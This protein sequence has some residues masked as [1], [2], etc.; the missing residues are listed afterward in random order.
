MPF[1]LDRRD[2]NTAAPSSIT[3]AIQTRLPSSTSITAMSGWGNSPIIIP[4]S[5]TSNSNSSNDP[6]DYNSSAFTT[7][8]ITYLAIIVVAGVLV[9]LISSR[10]F[11]IRRYYP[12]PS[13]RAYFL[14]QNGIH[15][16]KIGLHIKGAP[17][18]IRQPVMT[19]LQ[20]VYGASPNQ[21]GEE[22]RERRRRRR[23]R[24]TV[25][26]TLGP[27]GTRIGDRDSD[28]GWDY[29]DDIDL[30]EQGR[31]GGGGR[32]GELPQYQ[33]DSGLP[34]YVAPPPIPTLNSS[35]PTPRGGDDEVDN[36]LPSAAEYEALS[37]GNRDGTITYP[38][39]VHVHGAVTSPSSLYP[40]E[41]PPSFSRANSGIST[42]SRRSQRRPTT[43][44]TTTTTNVVNTA[45]ENDSTST[46]ETQPEEEGNEEG[47]RRR[48]STVTASSSA[49][50]L[51]DDEEDS[52]KV[53]T[54]GS[55]KVTLGSS[56]STSNHSTNNET[57]E[58][59]DTQNRKEQ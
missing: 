20:Q 1:T 2:A 35:T 40:S 43:T 16:D 30:V 23:N 22:R 59:E 10:Y 11:Y 32:G 49:S 31:G 5:S 26:E 36:Y 14:P 46:F 18:R 24:Q 19:T 56:S 50:K 48:Q 57:K 12:H 39:P 9:A 55:S 53:V 52:I 3:Q 8:W 45:N 6:Y 34:P 38:P 54:G 47:G 29:E 25:G 17:D 21:R 15:F 33:A 13:F 37:R 27:G 4:T 44:T 42:R 58:E 28:D 51:N 7:S 41:P